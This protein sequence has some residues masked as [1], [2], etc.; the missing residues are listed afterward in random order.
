MG[1]GADLIVQYRIG[2]IDAEIV[3]HYV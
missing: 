1:R 2:Q 3:L